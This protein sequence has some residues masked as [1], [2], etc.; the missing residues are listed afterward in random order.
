MFYLI[1]KVVESG[2]NFNESGVRNVIHVLSM[3]FITINI[4]LGLIYMFKDHNFPFNNNNLIII[5]LL[6]AQNSDM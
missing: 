3:M 1:F 6:R 2:T 4:T 5:V